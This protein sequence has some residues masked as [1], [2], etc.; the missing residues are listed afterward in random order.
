MFLDF[1]IVDENFYD[2]MEGEVVGEV[3][4]CVCVCM[5][6]GIGGLEL[7]VIFIWGMGIFFF[8]YFVRM[9]FGWEDV[10]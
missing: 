10:C 7:N 3:C 8:K 2:F 4:E 6:S 1:C 5:Y 9:L